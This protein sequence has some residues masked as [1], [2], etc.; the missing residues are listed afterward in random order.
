MDITHLRDIHKK[1]T[2]YIELVVRRDCGYKELVSL[3]KAK[4]QDLVDLNSKTCCIFR[5]NGAKV[6]N[7]LSKVKDESKLWTIGNYLNMLHIPG[8]NLRLGVGPDSDSDL[9][10]ESYSSSDSEKVC[11]QWARIAA[12]VCIVT[13]ILCIQVCI[14]YPL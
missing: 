9:D 11:M 7:G 2:G 13:E 12:I 3:M 5:A 6:V 8:D 4:F 1:V 14:P 10:S